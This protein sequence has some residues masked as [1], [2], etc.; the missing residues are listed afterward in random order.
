[1]TS[2]TAI[3]Q[4]ARLLGKE[5]YYRRLSLGEGSEL[6]APLAITVSF[7]LLGAT[8]LTLVV[9]PAVY[10]VVPSRI[11]IAEEELAAAAEP[12]PRS[13]GDQEALP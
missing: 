2:R 4:L 11:R 3:V 8:V 7:G 1:M 9:I 13:E 10:M 12:E 6:R 5:E